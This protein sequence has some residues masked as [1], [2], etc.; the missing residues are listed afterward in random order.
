M[1]LDRRAHDVELGELGNQLEGEFCPLPVVIDDRHYLPVGE[2]SHP[3]ANLAVVLGQG[4]LQPVVVHPGGPSI[5]HM[6]VWGL[7]RHRPHF[8]V[9]RRAQPRVWA[10][11][12]GWPRV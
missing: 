5:L 9:R 11:W 1:T 4:L 12:P 10:D 2:P 7:S 6:M 3:I 8:P